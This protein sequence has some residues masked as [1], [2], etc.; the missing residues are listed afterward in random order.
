MFNRYG[1]G[2]PQ[3]I[4]KGPGFAP[5]GFTVAFNKANFTS[6]TT[7]GLIL[8]NGE[9]G[10]TYSYSISSTGG[11]TPKTGTGNVSEFPLS[12]IDCSAVND[13]TLTV[14]ITLT[15]AYGTSS[16][17]TATATM[18]TNSAYSGIT[19]AWSLSEDPSQ[20]M[21]REALGSGE[22]FSPLNATTSSGFAV[23]NGTGTSYAGA[24]GD[25]VKLG[26]NTS[27]TIALTIKPT[28]TSGTR[29]ILTK[30]IITLSSAGAE[31]DI[32]H[33]GTTLNFRIF[34]STTN[35]T[36]SSSITAGV[37]DSFIFG[38]DSVNQLIS[39]KKNNGSLTTTA[40]TGGTQATIGSLVI[41]GS[42]NYYTNGLAYNGAVQKLMIWKGTYVTSANQATIY[43]N[44]FPY[45]ALANQSFSLDP[46]ELTNQVLRMDFSDKTR[47]YTDIS[48]TTNVVNDD[49]PIGR[50]NSK[51]GS[52]YAVAP[53]NGVRPLYKSASTDAYTNGSDS[54]LNFDQNWQSVRTEY[55]FFFVAKSLWGGSSTPP[56]KRGSHW[57]I[58]E[59]D[60]SYIVQT[61]ALA[62]AQSPFF[63]MHLT[64]TGTG[65]ALNTYFINN[66]VGYNVCEGF[67][68]TTIFDMLENGDAPIN[69]GVSWRMPNANPV[70]F[71]RMFKE[72]PVVPYINF[73][74][75]KGNISEVIFV[76]KQLT[77]A[78]RSRVRRF[79]QN[80]WSLTNTD[81]K[82]Y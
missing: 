19:R 40:W 39:I 37:A 26:A 16:P 31:W 76:E 75:A 24:D 38:Y 74:W 50:I 69:T 68:S 12:N 46:D 70:T 44:G 10:S 13:G 8:T 67:G 23:F 22:D 17:Q 52:R 66:P 25:G 53:S 65:D 32:Y 33:S 30:S 29:I 9:V 11:G 45:T 71:N 2:F 34:N 60:L 58:N 28:A 79:L 59:S 72:V 36:V 73:F 63:A 56:D 41:A 7:I 1:Y 5:S 80:K 57:F 81:Y 51:W 14:S 54:Q 3:N 49:D 6:K 27:F 21:L 55:T 64:A 82:G 43:T 47:M 61:G 15:N 18:F 78:E 20:Y 35:A 48:G 77:V 62:N 4:L 42:P